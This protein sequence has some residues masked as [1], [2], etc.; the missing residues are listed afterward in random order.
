MKEKFGYNLNTNEVTAISHQYQFS[1][2]L[3]SALKVGQK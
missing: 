3:R 1:L 2:L